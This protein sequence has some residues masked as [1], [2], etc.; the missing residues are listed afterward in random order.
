MAEF[1]S[2]DF[3]GKA[4]GTEPEPSSPGHENDVQIVAELEVDPR[5]ARTIR[6]AANSLCDW[7]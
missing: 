3:A 1:A 7:N 4:C 2:D 6:R 5:D